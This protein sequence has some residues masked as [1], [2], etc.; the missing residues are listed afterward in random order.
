[1]LCPTREGRRPSTR[2]SIIQIFHL[3]IFHSSFVTP[4]IMGVVRKLVIRWQTE[5]VGNAVPGV[6]PLLAIAECHRGHSLQ[7]SS[8]LPNPRIPYAASGSE[9]RYRYKQLFRMDV[10]FTA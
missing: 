10:L 6:P 4:A 5:P 9:L 1:M 2:H 8:A 3:S 7:Q